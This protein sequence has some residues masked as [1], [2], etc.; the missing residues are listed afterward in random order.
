MKA[1]TPLIRILL[2]V[3]LLLILFFSVS[4]L[5]NSSPA[6]KAVPLKGS[7]TETLENQLKTGN[8]SAIFVY[9]EKIY[10]LKKDSSFQTKDL[11]KRRADYVT[12]VRTDASFHDLYD[13]ATDSLAEKPSVTVANPET[14]NRWTSYIFPV[15]SLL[16]LGLMF[17]LIYRQNAGGGAGINSF[18]KSKAKLKQNVTVRFTDVAGAEEEKEE[19][20]EIVEFLKNPK[21]Y[22]LVSAKIPKGVLLV[23]PPGTG[24]TLFAKAVA[25]EANVP[26]FSTSG[27]EFV[28]MFVGAGAARV[29]DLFA[30][31]KRN[32]PCI[33]FIDEIDA[34]GR[35]RG[36]GLG[37]GNDEKEQ[38]LNQLLVEMDGFDKETNI[39]ILAA[40]NRS[41]VLD[42]A[43][44]RPGRFDRQ[45]FVGVPDIKGREE[46]FKVHAKNKP[47]S[48]DVSFKI[49]SRMTT[50]FTG[51]DIENL[52]NE[53]AILAARANRK[54]IIMVDI[55]E[56]INKVIAGPKKK[57]RIVTD[58]DKKITAYHECG[59]A[60]LSKIL[61]NCD[62]VQ[63]VSIVPRGMAAGY[64][65]TRPETDDEHV[66]K[67]KLNDLIAMMLAGRAAEE[68]IIQ[69]VTTGASN[70]IERA[71][72]IAKKMVT[73][74][75]MSN[76]L[77]LMSLG[78]N[79]EVFLG[80][81]YAVH[82]T[83]SDGINYM[84]DLEIKNILDTNY[85]KALSVLKEHI[86]VLHSMAEV[87]I[88]KDTIYTNEVNMLFEGK[89][90][91][92]VIEYIEK[93]TEE[94]GYDVPRVDIMEDIITKNTD[95]TQTDNVED[96]AIKNT[97]DPQ[98]M[99]QE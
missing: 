28:E 30:E 50:G 22:Q 59:H 38:T 60:I 94:M 55:L 1:K 36:A 61:E 47:L 33:V 48:K 53:A 41:D 4:L 56:A 89:S 80:R 70:D 96:I 19:L 62:E 15:L 27:S 29:R 42:P 75:G 83:T 18:V 78:G 20:Q 23:G 37:G 65:L 66:S 7:E 35:Q 21:K 9:G 44:V 26:F 16:G 24:K 86:N 87:L 93:K 13:K 6:P 71:T 88:A 2:T 82:N 97:Q 43:L 54:T 45:I 72:S 49:L 58:K 11:L 57:S 25:G 32:A 8:V 3:A 81:D 77:G 39:I 91:K 5:L 90:A 31:A 10:F 69:D 46:I 92:E 64:T 63:E 84:V 14:K 52:L 17:F 79:G 74:W 95:D 98:E 99:S 34:V 51:A 12:T 76:K 85:K 68:I 73:E 67:N 40:T